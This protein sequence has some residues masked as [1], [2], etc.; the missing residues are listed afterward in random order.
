MEYRFLGKTGIKVSAISFGN[1]L[2]SNNPNDAT[3]TV[4]LVKKAWDLGINFF[5]TAE[6]QSA[7]QIIIMLLVC[8]SPAPFWVREA[9]S[10][11][12][13]EMQRDPF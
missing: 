8:S 13:S 11:P 5:D 4:A 9:Y 12:G 1:C 6:V 7:S 2:N 3:R 10:P